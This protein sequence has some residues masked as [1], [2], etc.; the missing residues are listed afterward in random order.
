MRFQENRHY[1][2]FDSHCPMCSKWARKILQWDT[3]GVFILI[4]AHSTIAASWAKERGIDPNIF[5]ETIVYLQP[6]AFWS[7]EGDAL[8]HIAKNL[9]SLPSLFSLVLWI[10][11]K[12]IINGIY[13]FIS[14]N[15]KREKKDCDLSF[16]RSIRD[17]IIL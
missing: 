15:R 14:Q 8:K 16:D 6:N 7:K 13:R 4:S 12:V 5:S 17:R 1:V 11:P 9:K 2:F 3:E 10:T